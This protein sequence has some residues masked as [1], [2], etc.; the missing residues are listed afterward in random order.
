MSVT[1][2]AGTSV[3]CPERVLLL[4][5]TAALSGLGAAGAAAGPED[6]AVSGVA[7]SPAT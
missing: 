3:T 1:T 4:E 7:G 2:A 5:D 6:D